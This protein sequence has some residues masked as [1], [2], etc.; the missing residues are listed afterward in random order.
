MLF[1]LPGAAKLQI[2][3]GGEPGKWGIA[4]QDINSCREFMQLERGAKG[5]VDARKWSVISSQ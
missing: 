3:E 1:Q 5:K 4:P 2:G